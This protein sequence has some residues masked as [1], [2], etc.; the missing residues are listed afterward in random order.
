MKIAIFLMS[1]IR[2]QT[3]LVLF[4]NTIDHSFRYRAHQKN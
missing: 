2:S 3:K 4:S 1:E